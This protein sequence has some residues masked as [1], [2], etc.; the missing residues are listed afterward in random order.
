M[1][2]FRERNPIAV[3][4]AGLAAA[5]V[6]VLIAVNAQNLPI[7]GGGT[8]YAAAFSEAAGLRS[9]EHVTIAGV[10]VGKVTGVTLQDGHV[11]V[12]FRVNRGVRFGRYSRAAIEVQTLLG[13]HDLALDPAGPGQ[14][15]A[16]AE[17]PVSRTSTPYQVVP[18]IGDLTKKI[19]QINVREL[20]HAFDTLSATFASSPPEVRASLSGLSRLSAV[21]ASRDE[22]LRELLAHTKNVSAVLAARAGEINQIISDGDLVLR[23]VASRR[24]VIHQLLINTVVLAQQ[25]SGLIQDNQ[26]RLGPLLTH[27]RGVEAVLLRNQGNLDRALKLLGP[28]AREF[29]DATGSGRW[30]D[31]WVQNLLPV[32]AQVVPGGGSFTAGAGSSG[33]SSGNRSSG[34]SGNPILRNPAGG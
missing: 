25:V 29:A 3:G 26:A 32:P 1:K 8:N 11:R 2:P 17:I 4:V 9:G 24:A 33:G 12:D 31:G 19:E 16:G 7:I 27:L 18:A 21:I 30:L 14:F 34:G 28:F 15:P 20:A 22:Q 13:A 5:G 10:V 23:E 6:G